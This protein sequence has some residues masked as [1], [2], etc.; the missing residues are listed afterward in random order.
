[1]VIK[2]LASASINPLTNQGSKSDEIALY[3]VGIEV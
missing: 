1:M 2:K 3:E